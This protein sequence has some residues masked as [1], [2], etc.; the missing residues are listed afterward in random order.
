MWI[1]FFIL[2]G[3]INLYVAF[4]FNTDTWVY[5]KLFGM[6]GLTVIFIIVQS[7]YLAQHIVV[8]EEPSEESTKSAQ[9]SSSDN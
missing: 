6:M 4:N 7:I 3:V 9:Q 2:M 8:V 5:F 1:S